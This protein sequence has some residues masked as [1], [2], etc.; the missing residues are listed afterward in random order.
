[1]IATRIRAS[2]CNPAQFWRIA[3]TD[4]NISAVADYCV[5]VAAIR[6]ESSKKIRRGWSASVV[7]ALQ[8]VP[9]IA[10]MCGQ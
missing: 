1:M 7:V 10:I 5:N 3:T 2:L 8:V 4:R 9:V 6:V